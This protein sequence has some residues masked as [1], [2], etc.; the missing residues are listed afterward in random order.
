MHVLDMALQSEIQYSTKVQQQLALLQLTL[1]LSRACLYSFNGLV[2]VREI[3]H[4]SLLGGS[5][6]GCTDSGGDSLQQW[7]KYVQYVRGPFLALFVLYGPRFVGWGVSLGVFSFHTA[8][9]LG[10]LLCGISNCL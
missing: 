2:S 1:Q 8:S 10:T 9:S 3:M 5:S 7:R 4:H 6:A